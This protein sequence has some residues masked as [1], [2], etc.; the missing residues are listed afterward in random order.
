M[1]IKRIDLTFTALL[2]PL[3]TLGLFG[4]ALTAY[5]LRFS[6]FITDVRPII[7]DVPFSVYL[8][9]TTI[10][11]AIWILFF[12]L[13]GLYATS[14]RKAWNE[15]GR[16]IL[17]CGAGTILVIATVF[18]RREI[19]ASRF[20]VL[21][22]FGFS[23]LFVWFGRLVLRVIRHALLAAGVGHR[24]CVV[25]GT[26]R[27]ADDL[28]R[29][30]KTHPILGV[31]VVKHFE[32]WDDATRRTIKKWQE[33]DRLD[34][35]LLADPNVP[36][37]RALDL[38]AF[39]E[40]EH[41]TFMYLA[42][43]FAATFT[44]IRV[45]T[46]T[47]VPVIEVKRTPLDGW[48]RIAKRACDILISALL[49]LLTSPITLLAHFALALEDG[50]PV[51]FQNLRVGER[52]TLFK[53]YKLRTMWRKFSIGPQFTGRSQT[54]LELEQRL[55]K[56]R[57]IKKGPVY[58]I[59]NDP[60][61]TPVG[62]FLRRWSIDELPQ[63]WNVLRGDI[64]LVGPR[65][66]QPREV[67]KYEP[68]QR[69]VLAVRPGITG[70]AQISG[71]SDLAFEEEARLDMWYIEHWSLTLDLYILLKTPFVVLQRTGVY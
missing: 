61:V 70:M 53:T 19:P 31:T 46:D 1:R 20:I 71:R 15:L 24:L 67:E 62:R 22:V 4:A 42:D 63:L 38:I 47:G 68:R 65:P 7:Q 12:A 21:A 13:A 11:V 45:S 69:R 57:G 18:F 66:H 51:I 34:S 10:F 55:I 39:S 30:Y 25:I 59:A 54:N 9:R 60:R 32:T 52:G 2:I 33:K 40:E 56:E 58:K 27:A 5:A 35:I 41:L 3:D 43:L 44:N 48:G 16:I 29:T 8:S 26:S 6:R 37:D 14:P 17:A 23:I 50:I 64:S 28:V 36:K 49:L